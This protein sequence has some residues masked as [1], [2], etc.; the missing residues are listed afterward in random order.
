MTL[1]GHVALVTGGNSGIG[2]GLA[3]GLVQ[4]GADVAIWGTS[5]Q[6][7]ATA[8]AELRQSGQRVHTEE[9]DV[10]D[11]L[12]VA[13]SF[14]RTVSALGHVDSVFA[15][16]GVFGAAQNPLDVTLSDWRRVL[17]VN[18]D[19]AFL[20]LREGAQ[21][22]IARQAGGSL[23]VVSS[24]S[25]L[26][27]TPTHLPYAVS[28]SGLLGLTRALSVALA[29]HRIRV[30]ALL[31]GWTDT[32]LLDLAR[33]DSTFVANTVRRTPVRRWA[34]PAEFGAL[35]VFLADPTTT[36]HTGDAMVVDGGYTIF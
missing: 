5:E 2:L 27:G 24:I 8:A 3:S 29:R 20:T 23:V 9:C 6:K 32:A 13:A 28:K 31:P 26:H 17:A 15:N 1:E 21:H 30:N 25:A 11:E 12:Q 36:F 19:G 7:N 4:A 10:S 18:L 16:A 35:A 33:S 22:M 34:D 14:A